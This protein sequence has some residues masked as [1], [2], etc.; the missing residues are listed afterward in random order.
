MANQRGHFVKNS[1]ILITGP[2]GQVAFPVALAFAKDNEVW[3]IAR[4]SDADK[5]AAL[6]AAGVR[7]VPLDLTKGDFSALPADFDYV[8]NFA[9]ARD[10]GT[11]FNLELTANAESVGLLM[12]HCRKAKAFLH[13]SSCAVYHPN[14][15]DLLTEDSALGDNHRIMFPTYSVGKNAQEAVVRFAA[16]AYD[17][18]TVICRLNVPYGDNGGWPFYHLLMMQNNVAIPVNVDKPN[19]YNL[20][21]EDD[22][23]RSIPPLLAAA[24]VPAQIVNW[25][26]DELISIEE[27]SAYIGEL[28][29]LKPQLNY[30]AETLESVMCDNSKL[31]ALVG[32]STVHWKDGIRRM[33][34]T[35]KPELLRG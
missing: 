27:W 6:T 4:F 24:S 9:V 25:C 18:P 26:G 29:G 7:C 10:V 22:I 19:T 33:I 1:K 20:F 35:L 3:A 34:A 13:V 11:D 5:R 23:I 28:T 32:P 31:R 2:T 30:T 17:L 12:Q 14:G 8:L 15:H 21:H 16:R